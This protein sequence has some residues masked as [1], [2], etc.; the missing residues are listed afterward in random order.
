MN[1]TFAGAARTVTGSCY[2]L[3]TQHGELMVDRGLYQ[4][5]RS[6]QARNWDRGPRDMSRIRWLLLTHAHI[7]HSGLIPRLKS[8]GFRGRIFATEATTDLCRIMLADS[9]HIH[10]ED[11]KYETKKWIR[12]GRL[13][14]EPRPLYGVADAE[15]A[16]G[17]FEPVPY[18]ET[19]ALAPGLRA[20][21]LDA[22]HILGSA[23]LELWVAEN[24]RETKIVFSGDIGRPH[25]PILRDPTTVES[26]DL[27]LIEST[28]G[29]RAHEAASGLGR[30]FLNIVAT[31][32][33][34]G[35]HVVI[36]SFAVGRTQMII[37]H[38]NDL[39][40]SRRLPPIPTYIDSPLAVEATRV[41]RRHRECYD[42][43]TLQRIES[44]DD[45]FQFPNLHFVGSTAE[46]QRLNDL[47][48]QAIIISASGMCTAGRIRHH[49]KHNV[50]DP[51][52]TI[53]FVGYQAE[54][55]LGRKIVEGATYITLFGEKRRVRAKVESIQG[56]SAH[57]D[58]SELLGWLA[59]VP[60]RPKL[61]FAVHGETRPALTLAHCISEGLGLPAYVPHLHEVTDLG[62]LDALLAAAAQQRAAFAEQLAANDPAHPTPDGNTQG[63]QD[64]TDCEAEALRDA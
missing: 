50:G 59:A 63:E 19:V 25:V 43:A 3:D 30:A 21:F 45:P 11:A 22:G 52:N 39:I 7:D 12:R 49:L 54:N 57:A 9:G 34:V 37:Y 51:R 29:D 36:P 32:C 46:S 28:Y 6:L 33:S 44:G 53:L 42:P 18:N 16:L 58:Q 55:T 17:F 64:Q 27:L 38:L 35:G 14:P 4:G 23:T 56:F 2:I 48:G 26:A 24:G 15:E 1:L 60:Q 47:E 8:Q 31:T 41:F 10:E 5:S 40:E 13:G 20:R 62:Q 61:V